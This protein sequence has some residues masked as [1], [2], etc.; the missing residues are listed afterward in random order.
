MEGSQ[1]ERARGEIK[2][3]PVVCEKS[4]VQLING[5]HIEF[6]GPE[7]LLLTKLYAGLDASEEGILAETR[8]K[9]NYATLQKE[10]CSTNRRSAHR[11]P[12]PGGPKKTPAYYF[13]GLAH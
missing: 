7:G 12:R 11:V 8:A 3:T 6:P 2:V 10:C 9:Q 5:E 13:G 1:T 4:V